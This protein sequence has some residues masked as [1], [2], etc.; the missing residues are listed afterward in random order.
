MPRIFLPRDVTIWVC[1]LVLI[2]P[3][4]LW[5]NAWL[6][7]L[8]A[9]KFMSNTT[10]LYPQHFPPVNLF[11]QCT[12]FTISHLIHPFIYHHSTHDPH[13]QGTLLMC[14]I[15]S[16]VTKFLYIVTKFIVSSFT[17]QQHL[18]QL[19]LASSS[20]LSSLHNNLV[21]TTT[22]A[23]FNQTNILTECDLGAWGIWGLK[24]TVLWW[25]HGLV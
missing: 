7:I 17:W 6:L 20:S 9:P 8:P 10:T 12:P 14:S 11:P 23:N 24:L 16:T 18:R 5:L 13:C 19:L 25:S 4:I 15:F 3:F 2:N 22:F 21:F 1:A